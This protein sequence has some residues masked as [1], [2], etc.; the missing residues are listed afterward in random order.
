MCN[1]NYSKKSIVLN[2][3]LV[4]NS[5]KELSSHIIKGTLQRS[6]ITEPAGS[7]SYYVESNE[8]WKWVKYIGFSIKKERDHLIED[9]QNLKKKR[10]NQSKHKIIALYEHE[11]YAEVWTKSY[12]QS[13]GSSGRIHS[14]NTGKH[15]KFIM[16]N[17]RNMN[18]CTE[19]HEDY[20]NDSTVYL[21]LDEKYFSVRCNHNPCNKKSWVWQ[22]MM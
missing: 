20:F 6:L 8:I 21:N 2:F 16:C 22:P 13:I 7:N 1:K 4:F 17:I 11:I 12:L 9:Q 19:P 10:L 5:D 15:A 18:I 3:Y 14:I